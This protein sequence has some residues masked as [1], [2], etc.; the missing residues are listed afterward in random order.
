[1][2]KELVFSFTLGCFCT[3]LLFIFM[4][5]LIEIQESGAGN[6]MKFFALDDGVICSFPLL[7]ERNLIDEPCS[8]WFFGEG[9]G[10]RGWGNGCNAIHLSS[11]ELGKLPKCGAR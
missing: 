7:S 1:M 10:F 4:A 9:E 5:G 3:L 2:K 8:C 11:E 6:D